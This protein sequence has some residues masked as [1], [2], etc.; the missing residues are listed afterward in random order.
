MIRLSTIAPDLTTR[1]QRVSVADLRRVTAEV[2][3]AALRATEL[4]D[5][6]LDAAVRALR[7]GRYGDGLERERVK[8]LEVQLDETAWDL[9]DRADAG[10]ASQDDYLAAFRRARA[11]AALWF[12]LDDDAL[13]AALEAVYEARAATDDN[14]VRRVLSSLSG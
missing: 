3:D 2:V 1:L 9:Q 8:D 13:Q 10:D 5:Q 11:A 6:S 7:A 14:E 4:H 12:A